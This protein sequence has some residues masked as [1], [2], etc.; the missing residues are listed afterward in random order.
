MLGLNYRQKKQNNLNCDFSLGKLIKEVHTHSDGIC[1]ISW[2]VNGIRS[3][4]KKG[5]T[6]WIENNRPDIICLQETKISKKNE[7]PNTLKE[8]GYYSYWNF[9]EKAGYS[10]TVIFTRYKPK[11]VLLGFGDEEFDKEGRIIIVEYSQ[12]YLI[13]GYFP[14]GGNNNERVEFKVKFYERFLTK[15]DELKAIGKS[16]IFCGD[17]N[18]AHKEIDLARPKNNRNK[19]GFLD[20][21][22]GWIN[23]I[24]KGGY[25]DT[26][27]YFYPDKT[28]I[29]SYWSQRGS[30]RK[31]N[32][33]WRVDYFFIDNKSLP[34]LA[35]AFIID[36]ISVTDHCPVGIILS[37]SEIGEFFTQNQETY[38]MTLF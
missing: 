27:R 17:I 32:V 31:N 21:E 19:T 13:N 25:I 28:N 8:L 38:Q 23:T 15:C 9:A 6:T 11:N 14:Y 5:F 16:I 10:G 18:T 30:A 2:N 7:I 12:F 36:E 29:Y 24:I 20:I 35:S 33:G 26:F 1:I 37:Y 34:Y 3:L 4:E 22:R